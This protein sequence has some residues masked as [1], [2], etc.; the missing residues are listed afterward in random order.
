MNSN[1]NVGMGISP[2]HQVDDLPKHYSYDSTKKLIAE[3]NSLL[4]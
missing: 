3:L 2:S 1:Y 4:K